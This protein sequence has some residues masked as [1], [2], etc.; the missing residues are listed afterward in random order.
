MVSG[1]LIWML[2]M[3]VELRL[4]LSR[5]PIVLG[6]S[7]ESVV[8]PLLPLPVRRPGCNS[9]AVLLFT[10]SARPAGVPNSSIMSMFCTHNGQNGTFA[11]DINKFKMKF[12]CAF[13]ICCTIVGVQCDLSANNP[14]VVQG[15]FAFEM[16]I[17]RMALLEDR[18]SELSGQLS[19]LT[20]KIQTMME[21]GEILEGKFF[22]VKEKQMVKRSCNVQPEKPF[23]EPMSILHNQDFETGGWIVI[24]NRFD[25]SVNFYRNWE[26]YK[27]GFGNLEGEFWLGLDRIHQLTASGSYELAV[28]MEASDGNKT[29][30][31][32]DR[33]EIGN[34]CQKY[35]LTLGNYSGTAGDG[36]TY[37]N[38]MKF[39]TFD[40]DNDEGGGQCA[41]VYHGAW[42]YKS[43]YY[44]NLNGRH[45]PGETDEFSTRMIWSTLGKDWYSLKSSKMMIRPK[46][47]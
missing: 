17:N 43:C 46:L 18:N 32:Y 9:A 22:Y 44:S 8:L 12:L 41:V 40:E 26:E 11:S 42:W 33:F 16:I 37:S 1:P 23:K 6:H 13:I 15:G 25:G 38:G 4:P 7:W 2:L 31:K 10:V 47:G 5:P 14:S 20:A 36:L 27:N 29:Y 35:E 3:L 30:A 45:T 39:S 24:Q 19:N 34:E 21:K 28:L